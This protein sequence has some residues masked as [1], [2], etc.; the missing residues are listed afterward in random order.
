MANNIQLAEKFLPV[1]DDIYKAASV[2]QSWDAETQNLNFSN[3]NTVN[4][5]KVSTTGLGDYSR[6]D[7]YPKGDVTAEFEPMR[8]TEERG[9]EISVDRMDDEEALGKVFGTVT[10]DFMKH[11]VIPE[12][13]AFRFAK[14]ASTEGILKGSAVLTA[15]TL[16]EAID[17]AV[18]EMDANEVPREGRE[19][20]INTDLEP[21]ISAGLSRRW[22]SDSRVSTRLEEY[23]GMKIKYVVP[24]RFKSAITLNP[25]TD[26]WG[27]TAGEGAKN[28]NFMIIY[29]KAVLQVTKFAMPKIFTPDENQDKDAWKFQFRLYHDAF[30]YENK[31][32]GIY[33]HT[34]S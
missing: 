29:P 26:A 15:D 5:L 19:L 7:G 9:K 8:L 2:T 6:T 1:I 10:G 13:D 31:A 33:T 17:Q 14:Y 3:A 34:A 16:F 11:H 22:G 12:L 28:I 32:K 23:N 21:L 18:A 20:C 25:G 24:S 4:V 30:V 27:F